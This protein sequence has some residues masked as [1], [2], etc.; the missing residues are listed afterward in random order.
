LNIIDLN[1][2]FVFKMST[3]LRTSIPYHLARLYEIAALEGDPRLRIFR[4]IELYE[5]TLR[6]LALT[7]LAEY[8]HRGMDEPP[9]EDSRSNLNR[10]SLGH[11]LTL[12]RALD[13]TLGYPTSPWLTPPLNTKVRDGPF[14]LA[15]QEISPLAEIR[16]PK[17]LRLV[18]FIN[19]LV[20]FRNKKIGH[21][22]LTATEAETVVKNLEDALVSWLSGLDLLQQR[23]LI[24]LRSVTW[25]GGR[26]VYE[27]MNLSAGTSIYPAHLLGQEPLDPDRL[28]LQLPK[29][30]NDPL[31]IPLYPFFLFESETNQFYVY[32]ELSNKNQLILRCPYTSDSRNLEEDPS[33]ILGGTKTEPAP[34]PT[35]VEPELPFDVEGGKDYTPMRSWYDIITP[36]ADIRKGEFDEAIFAADLG[37]VASGRAPHDYRDPYMF[38]KKTYPTNGIRSML[39]RVHQTLTTGKGPSVIQVQTPFG[40]GKTH[41]LVAIYHYLKHGEQVAD[42]LPAGLEPVDARVTA[43]AGNHWN[44]VEGFTTDG[45]T[46][47]TFWGELAYQIGGR[48]GFEEFR[49]NDEERIS[50]GKD[51]LRSFLEAHQPFILLFDEILEYVNRALDVKKYQV[52]EQTGVSLGTQ[53]FSFFQEL[54]EAVAVLPQGMLI[55]TLP[56]SFI[57]N[58]G[59]QEE[60]SLARLSKIFGRLESIETP[61]QDEEIYAVIR[62]R[63]FE[64]EGMKTSHMREVVHGYFQLYQQHHQ[65]LPHK[66]R[67]ASFRDKMEMAFPF[68]PDV[69]DILY[70]KWSTFSTFQRTRGVLRLLANVV[71][72]LYE[73]E[74]PIDLILPGDID[75]EK[76]PIRREFL[77]HIGPEYEGVIASD[78]AGH[79]AKSRQLDSA[80]KPWKHLAQRITTSVF[81]HSFSADDSQRGINLPYIKLAVL[82]SD[83]IP[84]LATDV[85]SK[86]SNTLWFLNSRADSYYFSRIPNLNRMILDKKELFANAYEDE[87]RQVIQAEVGNRFR[88]YMW[89]EISDGIPDNRELKLVI[90]RPEASMAQ[91]NEW[92][93][94]K[95]NNFR[96]F[97]NTLFFALADAAGFGKLRE[98]VKTYLALQDIKTEIK[99]GNSPLP[100]DKQ[101][102][103]DRRMREITRDYSYN[104]RRMY[105]MVWY[106][107]TNG[108]RSLDLGQPV[109]GRDSLDAWYWRQLTSSETGAILTI[110]H[111]RMVVNKFLVNNDALSTGILLDQFYKNPELPALSE[112]GVLTRAIQL[113]IQDGAFGLVSSQ[114]GEILP[115]S[116]KYKDQV[117]LDAIPFDADTFLLSN[118]RC[119]AILAARVPEEEVEGPGPGPQEPGG[120]GAPPGPPH[121]EPPEPGSDKPTVYKR[122]NLTISGIPASKIAD[123]NRGILLPISR[124]VGDFQFTIQF[125]VISEDGISKAVLENQIKETIRQIGSIVESEEL[126]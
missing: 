101:E 90:M 92:I 46:R 57:E 121:G 32:N 4:L 113:G 11:W 15:S 86:L 88:V 7:R 83:T 99:S 110:L 112:Q 122:L 47:R 21:G 43:I 60:E 5:H 93:E 95:G 104:V 29:E 19:L 20:Q 48:R 100:L 53:T 106:G 102:E 8:T 51:K 103:V 59:E 37:D 28:Y 68:H 36:H 25:Q 40:G 58:Y 1:G 31:L 50:P 30:N 89:P 45:I 81:F 24:Y 111:Y 56:S 35:T 42:L 108:G 79:D 105:H 10:P 114:A 62:R 74:D 80:N 125:N 118:A 109:T 63:L 69:I 27:G 97:K 6:H 12:V 117:L 71:E 107:D 70:Q 22:S 2:Y 96:E 82:R 3:P 116:L 34:D 13:D 41:A 67:D 44:P 85:L 76:A 115:D 124:S 17:K 54:S 87:M 98:E 77:K 126:E 78:I 66:V 75:L 65:D 84:A 9:V 120:N 123:V 55:V 38:F 33:L 72:D 23:H 94:R 52:K 61:V 39:R 16:F 73:G 119:E 49:Q 18:F 14:F 91:V 26:F 64:V